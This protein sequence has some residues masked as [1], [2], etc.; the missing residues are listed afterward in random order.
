MGQL[1]SSSEE[2]KAAAAAALGGVVCGNLGR[3]GE[4]G[5]WVGLLCK[6]LASPD[7]FL[8]GGR[9]HCLLFTVCFIWHSISSTRTPTPTLTLN[10]Q[11][12]ALPAVQHRGL[13]RGCQAPLP[14]AAGGFR[15]A[16]CGLCRLA[17]VFHCQ[18]RGSFTASRKPVRPASRFAGLPFARVF[19]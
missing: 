13:P 6:S 11:V 16:F 19:A 4:A 3:C 5:D 9:L 18:L 15:V 17:C 12:P 14:A 1:Q 10:P 8:G 7:G 2:I